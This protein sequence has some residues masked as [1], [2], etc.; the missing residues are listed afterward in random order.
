MSLVL[1]MVGGGSGGELLPTDAILRVQATAGATVTITK[2]SVTKTD[3]GHENADDNTV[4]DYYFIIHAS[5]FDSVNPWTVTATLGG[6]SVSA[7]VVVDSANEYDVVL[8]SYFYVNNGILLSNATKLK[9]GYNNPTVN[10][11]SSANPF[12]FQ[13][14]AGQGVYF[15]AIDVTDY[16]TCV[17]DSEITAGGNQWAYWG[18]TKDN[19]DWQNNASTGLDAY[20]KSSTGRYSRATY[21]IDISNLTGVYFLKF[22]TYNNSLKA[23]VYSLELRP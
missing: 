4:Y 21:T 22:Y 12:Y 9:T 14:Q 13:I 2:G 18:F 1:N 11:Y 8:S 20:Y 6:S 15:D 10:I 17:I 3:L 7:T 5:Q 23:T 19:L 16:K